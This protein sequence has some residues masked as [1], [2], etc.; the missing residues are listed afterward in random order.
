MKDVYEGLLSYLDSQAE[1]SF[2]PIPYN[3]VL[4]RLFTSTDIFD[5]G[6]QTMKDE[7]E[8]RDSSSCRE[9]DP[10]I[11]PSP[12]DRLSA[13]ESPPSGLGKTAFYT[14]FDAPL[15]LAL[16]PAA[17]TR[18][19]RTLSN[20][21]L[22]SFSWGLEAFLI[23][24][25]TSDTIDRFP[26]LN[27]F[28]Y[29]LLTSILSKVSGERVHVRDTPTLSRNWRKICHT[30]RPERQLREQYKKYAFKTVIFIMK[31]K[32]DFLEGGEGL[33]VT[34]KLFDK[35][36]QEFLS[37]SFA[38]KNQR[39]D[40]SDFERRF[41][42]GIFGDVLETDSTTTINDFVCP[43]SS[44]PSL[45]KTGESGEGRKMP[46]R[47]CT[48]NAQYFQTIFR[49][50]R[51]RQLFADVLEQYFDQ[52]ALYQIKHKFES[53]V[54]SW[55]SMFTRSRPLEAPRVTLRRIRDQISQTRIKLAW[56]IHK[57]RIAKDI[58]QR[59][60]RAALRRLGCKPVVSPSESQANPE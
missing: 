25:F 16:K 6:R 34:E 28:D 44:R 11:Y 21:S 20:A 9:I 42:K 13:G 59:E 2:D 35:K 12:S 36:F 56:P 58:L 31:M 53:L 60:S 4:K 52:F 47:F 7:K 48:I 26:R 43:T 19:R 38:R 39:L 15:Q 41:Y 22:S 1:M 46:S 50:P 51:F 45:E 49:S 54:N 32:F 8:G 27:R 24:L 17:P 33:Q 29:A 57:V 3:P 40:R 5:F 55:R 30:Q 14:P 18:L 10:L 37:S 23:Q